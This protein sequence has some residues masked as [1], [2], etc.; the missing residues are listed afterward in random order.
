MSNNTCTTTKTVKQTKASISQRNRVDC[1]IG[2]GGRCEC[3]GLDDIRFLTIEHK[4]GGGTEHR[5]ARDSYGV[6]V[7]IKR[8][9]YDLAKYG[10][11]CYNC[12]CASNANGGVCPHKE[13]HES[14]V[15]LLPDEH[16]RG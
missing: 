5:N 8:S 6:Y 7:D 12:N 16:L 14:D 4:T 13:E 10:V 11:L 9:G 2:L 3:C 15:S 1:I